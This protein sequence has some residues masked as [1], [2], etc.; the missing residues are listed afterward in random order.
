MRRA[1]VPPAAVVDVGDKSLP[2]KVESAGMARPG[3]LDPKRLSR[4][5]LFGLDDDDDDEAPG[6]SSSPTLLSM[7]LPLPLPLREKMD[8]MILPSPML[9]PLS[10]RRRDS[11]REAEV[12]DASVE[13]EEDLS[14]KSECARDG[15]WLGLSQEAEEGPGSAREK[16]EDRGVGRGEG[17]SP[18]LMGVKP[19]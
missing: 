15:A 16:D 11:M 4:R 10:R 19:S 9:L 14:E 13:V 7:P 6:A 12:A 2:L 18:R 8:E 5:R 3:A 1:S 17:R